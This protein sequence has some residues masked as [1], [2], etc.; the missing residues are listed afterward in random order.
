MTAVYLLNTDF[1]V[2]H[3]TNVWLRKTKLCSVSVESAEMRIAYLYKN[4]CF[5]P[6]SR[7]VHIDRI[8]RE[9]EKY[10]LVI[11]G[12]GVQE[13]EMACVRRMFSKAMCNGRPLKLLSGERENIVSIIPRLKAGKNIIYLWASNA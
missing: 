13:I 3:V 9:G 1:E 4:Y 2:A 10:K 12:E 5:I 6:K 7:A 11:E 8:L